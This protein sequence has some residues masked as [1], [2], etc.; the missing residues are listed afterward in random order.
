MTRTSVL[1]KRHAL[2]LI[3][4]GNVIPSQHSAVVD[5]CKAE[6]PQAVPWEVQ[7]GTQT[8][9][10]KESLACVDIGE[11]CNQGISRDTGQ[12]DVL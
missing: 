4:L 8:C 11:K 6:G 3:I 7:Q 10:L 5:G 2:C 1:Q 12:N 9:T